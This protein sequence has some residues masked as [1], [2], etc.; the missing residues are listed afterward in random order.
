MNDSRAL[1]IGAGIGGLT[2]AL[3]LQRSGCRVRVFEQAAAL[4]EVGAG[5]T[6]TPNACHALNHL[7]GEEL[8]EHIC[9]VPASGA[10]K[11]YQTGKTLVDTRR[12]DRPKQKYGAHYC[13]AHRAD[14][15]DA[16]ADA[17]RRNDA[18]CLVIDRRFIALE[19]SS[20]GITARFADGSS[21]RGDYLVGCDGIHSE[22]RRA[23]WGDDEP[24]FTGY[25]AWRGL[26]PTAALRPE[27][28]VPDSAAF[29]GRG[30][31]FT[32][33]KVRRGELF[34][35][36]GFSQ[37]DEWAAESWSE[38][39]HID[40]ALAEFSDFAPEVQAILDAAPPDQCFKWG[41]FDRRPLAQWTKGR[42]TLLGDAG[43]PMTPF[44]A[45]G[46]AMAIE[47]GVVLARAVAASA[48]W[49]EALT[50]YEQARYERGTF[51]MLQSQVNAKRIYARDPDRLD[52]NS[53]RN[54]E[55]LGL[56]AYNP[57]TVP[58]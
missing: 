39:A 12:G 37:R 4:G 48:D 42:A 15:H 5:V 54:A 10:V 34:N 45:Q 56:Y 51:V 55:A 7:L 17:V 58:V 26:V 27:F 25:I 6:I 43:H 23:L 32:R 20:D 16:L 49:R 35:F 36:V 24:R 18:N 19:D 40:E 41:L 1:I 31:T 21:A 8:V 29:A 38:R 57:V 9:H 30:R 14:L 52:R 44:L 11:H 3:A 33:Y 2:A 50:R 13:Q 46:A 53:H 28:L 22:V 47:D